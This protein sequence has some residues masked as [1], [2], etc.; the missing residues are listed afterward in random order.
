VYRN[1]VRD[2]RGETKAKKNVE[3]ND[4]EFMQ[5]GRG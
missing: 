1:R 3:K 2:D 4:E 5:W